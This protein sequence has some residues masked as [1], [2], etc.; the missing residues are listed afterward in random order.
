MTTKKTIATL[1]LAGVLVIGGA[2]YAVTQQSQG[3][4]QT[5]QTASSLS[6]KKTNLAVTTSYPTS[7]KT[8]DASGKVAAKGDC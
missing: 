7:A 2:G 3:D 6:T 1:A 4:N 8:G 5:S